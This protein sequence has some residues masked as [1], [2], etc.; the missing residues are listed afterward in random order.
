MTKNIHDYVDEPGSSRQ[1]AQL[2]QFRASHAVT[3]IDMNGIRWEYIVSGTQ[4]EALL[5]LHGGLRV[6]ETAFPYIQLFEDT[7]R[8]I[9]PGYPP[10]MHIDEILDGIL[11]ILEAEGVQTVFVLGQSYGGMLAQAFAQRFPGR[12]KRLV[13]SNTKHLP[14]L[15][16]VQRLQFMLGRRLLQLLPGALLIAGYKKAFF[17]LLA[18]SLPEDKAFWQSYA[19]EIAAKR[20]NKADILSTYLTIEDA[21]VK[22]GIPTNGG[23]HWKGDVLI[24]DGEGDPANA[25]RI[26]ALFSQ[27]RVISIANGGHSIGINK[28]TEF[29]TVVNE[30][31]N[32]GK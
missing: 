24:V 27:A 2:R 1:E 20:W 13:L 19:D 5:L 6:A 31:F 3:E 29:A 21:L 16:R 17:A 30:F 22:Y 26:Q 14:A 12:V 11:A 9:T 10:A 25:E 4:G 28:P 23:S 8:V 32:G 7:Y 18:P 15:T